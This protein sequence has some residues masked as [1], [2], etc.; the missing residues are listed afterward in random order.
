VIFLYMSVTGLT[1][2][3]VGE[4][5]QQLNECDCDMPDK[6]IDSSVTCDK[7]KISSTFP[8]PPNGACMLGLFDVKA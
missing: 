6:N 2:R 1:I 8:R 7:D 3:H 5:F 4:H